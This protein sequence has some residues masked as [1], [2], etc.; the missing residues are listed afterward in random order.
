MRHMLIISDPLVASAYHYPT[1][2]HRDIP[3]FAR[4]LI[5]LD[6]EVVNDVEDGDGGVDEVWYS[7]DLEMC[8]RERLRL[9]RLED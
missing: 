8:F 9:M 5:A 7:R 2:K 1:V 3:A 6:D 4:H